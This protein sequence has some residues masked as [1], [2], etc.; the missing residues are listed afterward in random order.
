MRGIMHGIMHGARLVM[1]AGFRL[2]AAPRV[3]MHAYARRC[4][5]YARHYARNYARRAASDARRIS[6]ACSTVR[7]CR[8]YV[9]API[10]C[11]GMRGI[12]R[13][14][15][16]CNTC[17]STLCIWS[18]QHCSGV[19][20]LRPIPRTGPNPKPH[21][22][23]KPLRAYAVHMPCIIPCIILVAQGPQRPDPGGS[24]GALF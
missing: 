10:E 6:E 1:H 20:F 7:D 17:R 9:P 11:I 18:F 5:A 16:S 24:Q 8:A 3:V 21:M 22:I 12:I 15:A 4:F 23:S 2:R 14:K 13:R 19:P